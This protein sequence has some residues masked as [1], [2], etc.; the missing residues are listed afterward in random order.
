[1]RPVLTLVP[2]V[3]LQSA[4]LSAA[5]PVNTTGRWD[6]VVRDRS[7]QTAAPT[8]G[9]VTDWPSWKSL[10]K[11][12]RPNQELPKVDFD[13]E[14]VIVGVVTGPNRV[15]LRPTLSEGGDLRFVVAG[16]EMA[17]PGFGYALVKVGR[18]GVKTVNGKPMR[19]L[20]EVRG[21][22]TTGIMAIGGETTGIIV[23]TE[24][25]TWELDL[26]SG[27]ELLKLAGILNGKVVVVRGASERRE[28]V[29]IKERHIIKV[30]GLEASKEGA[31]AKAALTGTV[32]TNANGFANLPRDDEHFNGF[33]G[34]K[35]GGKR[36]MTF[37]LEAI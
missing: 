29:E 14:V 24:K 21:K 27:E 20:I 10:W 35:I 4:F 3:L 28:G 30:A 15:L 17:G 18:E 16:T 34:G 25:G 26:G 1:M 22:L 19:K 23:A 7:L 13:K 31:V 32:I 36:R 37:L 11:T 8:N 5:E 2:A 9:L 33:R 6:G 12:W